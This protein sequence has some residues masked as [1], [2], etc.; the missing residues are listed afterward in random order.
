MLRDDGVRTEV[1][2][3]ADALVTVASLPEADTVLAAI[4]GAAGSR[5]RSRPRA[6]ASASSSP[7]RKRS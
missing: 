7:T 6:P 4:V 2:G 3:G 5:R 1:L